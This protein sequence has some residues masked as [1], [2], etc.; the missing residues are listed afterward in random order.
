MWGA[1]INGIRISLA[2]MWLLDTGWETQKNKIF[3]NQTSNTLFGSPIWILNIH[4][5]KFA[6]F[7]YISHSWFKKYF[8]QFNHLFQ[9]LWRLIARNVVQIKIDLL[10]RCKGHWGRSL[11]SHI[12]SSDL[13]RIEPPIIT[14]INAIPRTTTTSNWHHRIWTTTLYTEE[15]SGT[16]PLLPSKF[17]KTIR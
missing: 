5:A 9:L 8:L 17:Y 2:T 13:L 6:S 12:I 7:N 3:N 4:F 11:S 1:F 16:T 14:F 15:T 10:R